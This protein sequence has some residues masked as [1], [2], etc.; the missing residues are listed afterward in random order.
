M[1]QKDVDLRVQNLLAI[2]D[3][4]LNIIGVTYMVTRHLKESLLQQ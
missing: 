2:L 1:Y 3:I 4:I